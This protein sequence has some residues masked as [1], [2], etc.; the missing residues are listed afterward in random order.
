MSNRI[1]LEQLAEQGHSCCVLAPAHLNE[2]GL[3]RPEF[4][5]LLRNKKLEIRQSEN[6]I[7][8]FNHKGV[9]VHAADD[10]V[11]LREHAHKLALTFCPTWTMVATEDP[12]QVLLEMALEYFGGRVVYLAHTPIMVPADFTSPFGNRAKAGLLK[13]VAV[14]LAVSEFVKQYI[15]KLIELR[16]FAVPLNQ[17]PHPPFPNYGSFSNGYITMINPSAQKGICIFLELARRMPHLPFA[18]VAS[19][20]TS[21]EDREALRALPNVTVLEH[22]ED[23]ESFYS[24]TR[25]LLVPSV[26]QEARGRVITEAMLRGIP[27]IASDV[28][29]IPEA[30]LG[31]DYV[32]PV[33]PLRGYIEKFDS[34]GRWNLVADIPEQDVAPW[35]RALDELTSEPTRYVSLSQESRTRAEEYVYNNGIA[36]IEKLFKTL[37]PADLST[38]IDLKTRNEQATTGTMHRIN[39][40]DHKKRAALIALLSHKEKRKD[41]QVIP[42]LTRAKGDNCFPLS[43]AQQRLWFL[44][45]LEPGNTT[46]NMMGALRLQGPLQFNVLRASTDALVERH[47]ILRTHFPT[48]GGEPMQC[49]AAQLRIPISVIDL[50]ALSHKDSEKVTDYCLRLEVDT[51]FN[52]AT[53]PLFRVSVLRKSANDHVLLF[54]LHHIISDGWSTGVLSADFAAFYEASANRSR[55]SLPPLTIQYADYAVWHRECLE[56]KALEQQLSYWRNKLAGYR[57]LK[58]ATGRLRSNGA[59]SAPG[60]KALMEIGGELIQRLKNLAIQH[61]ITLFVT[62]LTTFK[63]LLYSYTGR[64]DIVV[65]TDTAGRSFPELENLIGFFVNQLVLRTDLSG[66]PSFSE[67]MERVNQTTLEAYTHDAPFQSVVAAV[68]PERNL[69]QTPFV[70]YKF[71]LQSI[72][73]RKRNGIGLDI[74]SLATPIRC[75]RFDLTMAIAEQHNRLAGTIEYRTD[76]FDTTFI[77]QFSVDFQQLLAMICED[78]SQSLSQFRSLLRTA[79]ANPH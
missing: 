63:F 51:P 58:L 79:P 71:L 72:P 2:D 7:D 25:I 59:A 38:T 14:V 3:A 12:G 73:E 8:I 76:L 44:D 9:E 62:L 67:A 32:I 23:V 46:Y 41:Q 55:A 26:W 22:T 27:V 37:Q 78:P 6:G 19:W 50:S 68:N 28:G 56:G 21:V 54:T 40:L 11:R 24:K 34:Q 45:Q 75:S 36:V 57:P 4:L 10:I 33:R 53:G 49:T 77:K 43:F 17:F 42:R 29:G 20:G 69:D 74:D 1:L 70:Q 35:Q 52:L 39:A 13:K 64:T 66:D 16:S 61:G 65:G 5:E 15:D 60:A 18:A 30:K 48:N 31:T 47:E